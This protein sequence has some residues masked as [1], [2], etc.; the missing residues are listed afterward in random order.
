MV[1][2]RCRPLSSKLYCGAYIKQW[3]QVIVSIPIVYVQID[4]SG[5]ARN[6]EIKESVVVLIGS[7]RER[8]SVI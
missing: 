7:M 2:I 4:F 3:K 1:Q 8:D 5:L 6:T